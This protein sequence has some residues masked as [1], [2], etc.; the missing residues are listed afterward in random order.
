MPSRSP[1]DG[2]RD[3]HP[4]RRAHAGRARGHAADAPRRSV[5]ASR[6]GRTRR[7][8]S[9]V[10]M[11]PPRSS[12]ISSSGSAAAEAL[13]LSTTI[14]TTTP[15]KRSR[16]RRP[17]PRTRRCVGA[18]P[19]CPAGSA[20]RARTPRGPP[21]SPRRRPRLGVMMKRPSTRP[22]PHL[23]RSGA[24]SAFAPTSGRRASVA[25][26][27]GTGR[28]K[29]FVVCAAHVSRTN[30][31][32]PLRRHRRHRHERHR[33]GPARPS[34]S[35]VIGLRSEARASTRATSS[36]KGAPIRIGHRAENVR[37]PTSSCSPR[38]CSPTNPELVEAR[39]RAIPVIPR[40]EMLAELMRLQ[41]RHRDRRLARQDHDDLARRH[42]APRRGPRSDRRHRRQ[43]ERARL[44][45]RA[46]RRRPPRRRGRRVATARS[47]SSRRR[48]RSITNIDPEHLDHY[49]DA[50]GGEGRVRRLREPRAV[51]RA[52]RRVPRSS[53][54][55]GH[56]AAHRQAHRD[57]RLRRAGGLPRAQRPS[58]RGSRCASS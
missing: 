52:R 27:A 42:G 19:T 15:P 17:S 20:A 21:S 56:P 54:R 35:Q 29:P 30:S 28:R 12:T 55:A 49:G 22:V 11:R 38:R 57:L 10:P 43:A 51:L 4:R 50:R 24:A 8:D 6:D 9:V 46:R 45:R 48:S 41:G 26:S 53:A 33:R 34:A 5:R 3:L 23:R 13:G 32:D 1:R 39:R 40:A 2:R 16:L 44:E 37:E 18:A 36:S 25:T 58:S 14:P 7:D 47:C 31:I